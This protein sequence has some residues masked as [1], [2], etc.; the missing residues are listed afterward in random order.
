[1]SH[2]PP[3]V[4]EQQ[5][6]RHAEQV[7]PPAPHDEIDI[8]EYA[9]HVP[10]I[11]PLQQPLG[12]VLA[13]HEQVPLVRSQ[14]PFVQDTHAAPPVPQLVADSDAYGSHVEPLQQPAGHD[15][16]VQTHCPV[17]VLHCCPV[18]H[19]AHAAPPAPHEEFVSEA[20]STQVLPLQQPFGHE[21]ALHTHCPLLVLHIWPVA[22]AAHAAPPEPQEVFDS[23]VS[24]SHVEPLQQPAHDIVPHEQ[25]PLEQVSPEPHAA[26]TAP[27]VP[28]ELF[29]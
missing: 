12:H 13:S 14:R 7:A 11:P 28:H 26:H 23:L 10:L 20:Y 9:S 19:D 15:V 29:D 4:V 27:P 25:T 21:V 22:H 17:V 8:D 5:P 18:P 2:L 1:M 24:A 16:D 3:P 6:P